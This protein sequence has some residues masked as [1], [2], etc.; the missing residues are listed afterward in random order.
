MA[1][2]YPLFSTPLEAPAN[3]HAHPIR[4]RAEVVLAPDAPSQCHTVRLHTPDNSEKT[5][6]NHTREVDLPKAL[7]TRPLGSHEMVLCVDEKTSLQPRTA[8]NLTQA[9]AGC[10]QRPHRQRSQGLRLNG[11]ELEIDMLEECRSAAAGGGSCGRPGRLPDGRSP[12]YN[13]LR[14]SVG[15][16]RHLVRSSLR[17]RVSGCRF[18]VDRVNAP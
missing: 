7:Y 13:S 8:A 18:D 2:P 14:R 3:P 1:G 10:C 15:L 4:T 17:G 16:L 6:A 11:G 9:P 12:G 5:S